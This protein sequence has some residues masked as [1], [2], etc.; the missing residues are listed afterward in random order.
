MT[1]ETT[2]LNPQVIFVS[3]T[4]PSDTTE[5][6]IWYN[7]TNKTLY[8]SNGTNYVLLQTDLT[9]QN[10]LIQENALNIL[11]N[12]ASASTTLNDWDEMILDRFTDATGQLNTIDTTNTTATFEVNEYDNLSYSYLNP[13]MTSNTTP[14]PYV[15]SASA[16]SQGA[17]WNAFDGN[18]SSKWNPPGHSGDWVK[19]DVGSNIVINKFKY[20]GLNSQYDVKG[21]TLQGSTDDITYT[22]LSTG[23][24]PQSASAIET[25][26]SNSTPYRYYKL[27]VNSNQL[28]IG[29][30]VV[31]IL[32]FSSLIAPFNKL[33][34]T[35]PQTID[36]GVNF[37]QIYSNNTTSGTG[38]ITADV[39]VDGGS[40]WTTGIQLNTKTAIT[41]TDGTSLIMKLNLNAGASEGTAT[42]SDYAIMLF[43]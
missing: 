24:L 27:I 30:T 28:N 43:Y 22:T 11:V 16:T 20:K 33:I 23:N 7:T 31:S 41:S 17:P 29:G 10:K 34:Q 19:L 36:S 4:T 25:S 26:F 32:D 2:T 21:Y 14:S 6:K 15:A 38:S 8:V 42:A 5:G 3:A 9:T 39:S 40:T 12:S 35:N 18:T 13:L 1:I 37:V